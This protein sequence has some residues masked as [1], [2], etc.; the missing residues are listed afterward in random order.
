MSSEVRLDLINEINDEFLDEVMG[1]D[2]PQQS[3][4]GQQFSI[5][6]EEEN[7][8]KKPLDLTSLI[9]E[10]EE[11][12]E[13]ENEDDDAN[14]N[15]GNLR[16][17]I[18]GLD[19]IT[20][21][22]NAGYAFVISVWNLDPKLI[23]KSSGDTPSWFVKRKYDE[24]YVLDSRLRQFH[25]GSLINIGTANAG[26]AA[27]RPLSTFQ[28]PPKPRAILSFSN[29]ENNLDYLESVQNDFERYLQVIYELICILYEVFEPRISLE[30][31]NRIK[32]RF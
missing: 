19:E 3:V 17:T 32:L 23:A 21:G 16:V 29:K 8:T 26:A 13:A 2:K 20:V 11:E 12:E 6:D 9:N 10:N 24:F 28:L 31:T 22:E 4:F 25:G 5:E 15:L 14:L 30:S 7:I 27:N 18:D 1:A